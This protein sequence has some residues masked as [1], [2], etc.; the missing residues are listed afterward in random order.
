M[1]IGDPEQVKS[2][3]RCGCLVLARWAIEHDTLHS[4]LTL[5]NAHVENLIER[6]SEV[7]NV[8]PELRRVLDRLEAR[9]LRDEPDP[10]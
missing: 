9:M 5:L 6:M 2:C 10:F 7:E 1:T 4:E 8:D 3:P